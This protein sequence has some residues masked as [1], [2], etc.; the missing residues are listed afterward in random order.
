MPI[1]VANDGDVTALAGAMSLG[2]GRGN[3]HGHGHQRGRGLCGRGR[4]HTG[5]AQRAGL[6]PGGPSENAMRDEWSTDRGGLQIFL[7]TLW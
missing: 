3:G 7:R 4:Q 1:V 6:R 5:L 2:S